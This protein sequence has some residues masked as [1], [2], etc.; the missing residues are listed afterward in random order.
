ML[1]LHFRPRFLAFWT[2]ADIP[3]ARS[4]RLA[5]RRLGPT[6]VPSSML[7][8][9]LLL[10]L[11]VSLNGLFAMSELAIV[12]SRRVRLQHMAE[13]G[14]P[15][16][17]R[18]LELAG[19]PT[20]FLSTVQV[21]ITG[22]GVLLGAIGEAS[23]AE[24]FR[25][26]L[27]RWSLTAPHAEGIALAL[28]VVVVTYVSLIVGELVPKRI[29]MLNPEP[30]AVR[31]ARPMHWLSLLSQPLVRLLSLSTEGVL[32]LLGVRRPS[33][34]SV[35]EEE[36]K[37]LMEQ[38]TEEGVFER[39]ELELVE[40]I[41]RLD[42][43]RVG[44][45]MTPRMEIV[46]VDTTEAFAVNRDRLLEQTY[47]EF[48]VCTGGLEHVVGFV[49]AKALL[50]SLL[51]GEEVDFAAVAAPPLFVP[52]TV[53]LIQLL[54]QFKRSQLHT[55]LVV[56]EYGEISGLVSLRDVLDA[57]VGALPSG[58][59]EEAP[60]AVGREDGSWLVD[61]MMDLH[62][63]KQRFDLDA[64]P[65][66]DFLKVHTVGGYVMLSLGRVPAAAEV[67]EAAGLR[68][69]VVDMDGRRVDKVL[70]RRMAYTGGATAEA[71]AP[72]GGSPGSPR[73]DRL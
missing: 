34:P 56:D 59:A 51:A 17:A 2:L 41:L 35:T 23:L 31:V 69:E 38:G 29:A 46:C 36:I 11:L 6:Q 18:A 57:I 64:L 7:P 65:G 53:T 39:T 33:E 1:G 19:E 61:G 71:V 21:G 67:F 47:S 44:A 10:L 58:A 22:I 24:S 14:R 9:V 4:Q 28:M 72:H 60:E 3:P 32:R 70:V 62:E 54:E 13:D 15:G 26:W 49:T 16:A 63:L 40:N 45:V 20:R 42:I 55:A 48:P 43:R 12:S 25:N 66:E 68:F 30:I 5:L 73:N 8:E 37:I 27:E 52:K 50:R